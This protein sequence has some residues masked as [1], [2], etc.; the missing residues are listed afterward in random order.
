[1]PPET[2]TSSRSIRVHPIGIETVWAQSVE[3]MD[4]HLVAAMGLPGIS[5]ARSHNPPT[6][7]V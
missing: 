1:M 7:A 3:R 2:N 4:K 6:E 5:S